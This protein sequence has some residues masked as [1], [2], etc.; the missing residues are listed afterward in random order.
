MKCF[1]KYCEYKYNFLIHAL[2][3]K[4]QPYMDG[5]TILLFK[6]IVYCNIDVDLII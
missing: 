5:N 6:M 3:L 2:Y 1:S 4:I